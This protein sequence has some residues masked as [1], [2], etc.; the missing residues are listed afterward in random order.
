MEQGMEKAT[1]KELMH[2]VITGPEST[3]KTELCEKLAKHY[4]TVYIPEYAREY[5][6][7]LNRPYTYEDV[8][9][10][11]RKQVE[12]VGE[13]SKSAKKILFYDT[14]LII[15]KVWF[16][17]VYKTYP[18]WIDDILLE[19]KI[20]LFLLCKP[21]IPWIPDIVRENGGKMRD[22]LFK[23]YQSELNNFRINYQIIDGKSRFEKAVKYVD[24]MLIAE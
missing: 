24:R 15:T 9:H 3:G 12:L 5:V 21:D 11:A 1:D 20:D 22:V 23:R 14:Y 16:E 17:V 18:R 13:Y 7:Q 19:N 8:L 10:I 4:H 2:I 6:I